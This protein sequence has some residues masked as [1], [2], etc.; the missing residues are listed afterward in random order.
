MREL[1]QQIFKVYG[2]NEKWQEDSIEFY[3]AESEEK[4]SFF[5]IDYIEAT[6]GDITEITMLKMLKKL[7]KDYINDEDTNKEGIKRTIQML[8]ANANTNIA[9]QID[10]NTSA[11][12]PIKLDSLNNLDKYRNLIYSVEESPYYFRRFVLPYT[13][14]QVVELKKIISDYPD[15]NIANVLSDIANQEDAY[16]ELAGHRNLD[17]AYEL[18]IRLFSKIPFL[19]YNFVAQ[20]KPMAVEKRIKLEMDAE[21]LKYHTLICNN[22][23]DIDEYIKYSNLP[24]DNAAIEAE[25]KKRLEK[26]V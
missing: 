7:E 3:A 16:Y 6:S 13:E 5:L 26:K 12:Y 19:Q 18:V 1:I 9:A 15:K 14:K 21:L 2:F 23:V 22:C 24:E 17:N 4:I 8:I 25:I 10:K 11:I 20:Q